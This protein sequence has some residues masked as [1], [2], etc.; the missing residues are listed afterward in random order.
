MSEATYSRDPDKFKLLLA[1]TGDAYVVWQL[2]SG[3]AAFLDRSSA[4]SSGSYAEDF[5][6]RG[7]VTIAKATSVVLLPGQEVYWDHSA[8]NVTYKRVNDRD[9]FAGTVTDGATSAATTVEIDLNKSQRF[10]VDVVND[11][12][13]TVIVGTQV[14]NT[15]GVLRRGS[16]H[17][18]IL[19]ATSEAQKMD[20]LSIDGFDVTAN[21][22]VE[23][24]FRVP[25]DGAGTV[26]DVS[27]GLAN[28]THATD[29]DSITEHCLIHL[30]ANNTNINAQS[31]VT[32]ATVTATDTTT[33]YVE[34][35]AVA[36]RVHV[37]MD[38]R[39]QADIQIYVNG[40]LV[41]GSTVFRLDGAVGPMF[42]L[43]HIEKTSS[44]DAYEF[45]LDTLRC[46]TSE[47]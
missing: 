39:D 4:V 8:N 14:L 42:L 18:M 45:A 17:T 36:N 10:V 40:V 6:T 7:K 38:G 5:R 20:I 37:L 35:S 46:W 23:A 22:I 3:E 27:V 13:S 47:Q 21:W 33:D 15:M 25:S 32:A 16:S 31:K 30:D 24:S 11:P 12:H 2:P 34:G 28:A 9:F 19:N 1:A 44:T 43:A 41:L 29:A 26:V